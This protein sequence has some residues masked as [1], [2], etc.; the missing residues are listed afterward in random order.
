MTRHRRATEAPS[1][2]HRGGARATLTRRR[3]DTKERARADALTCPLA[4]LQEKAGVNDCA[5]QE[6]ILLH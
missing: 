4:V 1:A 3:G 5:V 6:A 2:S